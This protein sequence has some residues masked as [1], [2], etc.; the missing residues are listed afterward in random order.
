MC[1][2][3]LFFSINITIKKSTYE[4]FTISYKKMRAL[5]HISINS[6][7]KCKHEKSTQTNYH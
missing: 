4:L 6:I 3:N 2:D 7:R 1:Y 5:E